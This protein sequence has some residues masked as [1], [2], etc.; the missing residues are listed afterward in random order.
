MAF[1]PSYRPL[2]RSDFF[3][4][5]RSAR[6]L[7]PGTVARGQLDL[8]TLLYHGKNEK[9]KDATDFPFPMTKEVLQRGR[10]RFD[11]FCSVCHGLAGRADGRIVQ[12]GFTRPPTFYDIRTPAQ[13]KKAA[14]FRKKKQPVPEAYQRQDISRAHRLHTVGPNDEPGEET[15]LYRMPVGHYFGVI[16]NGFGAMPDY[17]EQIPVRDR[18]AIVGYVR[19]LQYSQSPETRAAIRKGGQK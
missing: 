8:D 17:A 5:G 9:G 12:R 6:P 1:Q 18:W 3:P 11:I 16:T 10:Q 13:K 4:D 2:Q 19:V 14:E 15:P 7:L